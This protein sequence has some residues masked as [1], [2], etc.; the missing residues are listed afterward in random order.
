MTKLVEIAKSVKLYGELGIN[1][2]TIR[3][4]LWVINQ[5]VREDMRQVTEIEG[6]RQNKGPRSAFLTYLQR[7]L[8][9][10]YIFTEVFLRAEYSSWQPTNISP[11]I[12]DLGGDPGAMSALYW[13]YRS[14]QSRVTVVEANPATVSAMRKNLHRRNI[15][16]VDVINAVIAGDSIGHASLHLHKPGKGFH[17]QDFACEENASTTNNRFVV[18]VP[19]VRLSSL[20][21]EGES[22]HLLKVDI[23]GSETI[24]MR[25]LAQSGKMNQIDQIIMEYHHSAQEWPNNSL[26]ETLNLLETNNFTIEKAHV[27]AGTGMRKKT[28]ISPTMLAGLA[29]QDTRLFLTFSAVRHT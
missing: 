13:K 10:G 4:F 5:I 28:C 21:G 29:K 11:R 9:V 22:V 1:S 17:T 20:I 14:P 18:Q 7:S 24:A 15:N 19:K 16:H 25:E 6:E 23:E 12:I 26:A 27:T 2:N 8:E 3:E